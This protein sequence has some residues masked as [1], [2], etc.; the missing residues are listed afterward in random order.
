MKRVGWLLVLL[1][2]ACAAV[3]D[4]KDLIPGSAQE[5]PGAPDATT[6]NDGGPIGTD[7]TTDAPVDAPVDCGDTTASAD[8]CGRCGH[9]CLGGM[10]K[11]SACQAVEIANGQGTVGGIAVDATHVYFASIANNSVSR[12]P[13]TGGTVQPIASSPDVDIAKR[14]AVDATHVYWANADCCS[15]SIARCPITGCVGAAQVIAS[16]EEGFGLALDGTFVYWADHNGGLVQRRASDGTGAIQLVGK[17]E[18]ALP[19]AVAV[20]D[21]SAFYVNDFSGEVRRANNPPDGG[22]T[23]IGAN[24]QSGREIALDDTYVYWSAQ[25]D[26][27]DPGRINRAP[28]SGAGPVTLVGPAGGESFGIAVDGNTIYWTAQA[29]VDGGPGGAVYA[30]DVTGCA[31]NPKVIA[32]AQD[33]PR[34]IAVDDKAIYWGNNGHIVKLAKP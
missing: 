34:G 29:T 21:G 19:V 13:K 24:G 22:S 16:V 14:V 11:A 5:N 33:L 27:G 7:A 6:T 9:S 20:R 15:E 31:G 17:G 28:R 1:V 4:I 32:A 3:L 2:P 26:P 25:V 30:C 12:V 18:G 23:A 8:N 10:C